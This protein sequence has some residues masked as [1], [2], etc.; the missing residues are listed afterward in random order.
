M[1]RSWL[2]LLGLWTVAPPTWAGDELLN[3]CMNTKHHKREPGPEDQL[4]KE[5]QRP[6]VAWGWG[7]VALAAQGRDINA[8]MV[9]E[10]PPTLTHVVP[11]AGIGA[12]ATGGT[13][14]PFEIVTVGCFKVP[15]SELLGHLGNRGRW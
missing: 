6:D 2:L 8:T 7:G 15:I 13:L 14:W 10:P 12:R 9:S 3:V 4:Y 11:Y 5:V 1:D